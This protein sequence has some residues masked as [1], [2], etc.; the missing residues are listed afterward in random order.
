MPSQASI[1]S[2]HEKS[3]TKRSNLTRGIEEGEIG[4]PGE[5]MLDFDDSG[6]QDTSRMLQYCVGMWGMRSRPKR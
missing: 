1:A 3:S 5:S 4:L 2:D 6:R